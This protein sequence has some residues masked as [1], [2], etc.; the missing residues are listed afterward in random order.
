MILKTSDEINAFVK[1]RWRRFCK[2]C[3]APGVLEK[4]SE[5]EYECFY[6]GQTYTEEDLDC[7]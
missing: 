2:H 5:T 4:V 7:I 6:C 1:E 3:R